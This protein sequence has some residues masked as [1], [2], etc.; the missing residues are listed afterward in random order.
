MYI[1]G[2]SQMLERPEYWGGP[3]YA[4]IFDDQPSAPPIMQAPER[5]EYLGGPAYA[6][7]SSIQPSAPPIMQTPDT[8]GL[9]SFGYAMP[10][11]GG[12]DLSGLS[13]M[14]L[15]GLNFASDFGGGGA[16]YGSFTDDPNLQRIRAPVSNRGNPT[17]RSGSDNSFKMTA[18]QPVRLVD[19]HTNTVVF[20][21]VG[22]DA[23][24][25]ATE[26][27]QNLT[28]TLGRK[29]SYDIQTADPS[30]QYSTVANEKRNKSTL[31]AIANVAGAALP[32]AMLA[33]PAFG[34]LGFLAQAA[35]GA[36]LG[37][38]GAGLQ[39]KNVLKGA[40]MGGLT[41]G[42]G[43]L[44]GKLGAAGQLGSIG[45]KTGAVIGSGLGSTAGGIATGQS[46]GQALKG[47]AFA[48]AG[49]FAGQ[50][51]AGAL[52]DLGVN[53][54]AFRS[55]T[56][57]TPGNIVVTAPTGGVS[58]PVGA[59]SSG[60]RPKP[61]TAE[62]NEIIVSDNRFISGASPFYGLG[63]PALIPNGL[64]LTPKEMAR[65]EAEREEDPSENEITV[66][67]D[68]STY[69]DTVGPNILV[70]A[71]KA[72]PPPGIFG[73]A[74][75]G[76]QPLPTPENEIIVTDSRKSLND[77]F[78]AA[79]APKSFG[80]KLKER[81]K[82]LSVSDYLRLA[83]LGIGALGGG[84]GGGR[85][86]AGTIPAGFGSGFSP[87][88]SGGLP[89]PTLPGATG[90]FAPRDPAT[91]RPQT[92][93]D[94]YRYGYGPAQ[95][96]FNYVPQGG[97]NKSQ[98]Y[99]G[100]AEGGEVNSPTGGL[101]MGGDSY[102]VNGAGTGRSDEIPA[103]LSDGEYVMDAETV[104]LLGDGSSKAGAERLDELR[105]K[106]RKDKGRK[107]AKGKF[108]VNAKRPEQYLTGGRV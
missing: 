42:A 37:G 74:L 103:L 11:F 68:G 107:L 21:G 44:G 23:A 70:N 14:N 86:G 79:F 97:E 5:P 45:A 72:T 46:V 1:P 39:G 7:V 106:I 49:T 77:D 90:N 93:Q 89:A 25:K 36:G 83:A 4:Q 85:P 30:G 91:L 29:A 96:F 17:G 3:A 59:G 102:P 34:Q 99:T 9:S 53:L 6:P 32:L 98:A 71:A 80:D 43:G 52:R 57:F 16:G 95:S 35:I 84:G 2:F 28:D 33:I 41:A 13:N 40:V 67:G 48:A 104:A 26:M 105:V 27:G 22:F 88:F 10:D 108:S 64:P 51:A 73:V 15:Q 31:G 69:L 62:P 94:Y 12:I 20:E 87:V 65:P 19:L 66:T 50:Q 82:D 78:D 24:R 55:S 63:T 8:G 38:A 92:P 60:G 18:E 61:P 58:I 76:S 54:P 75:G 100:Y 101:G 47:G 81:A 56:P